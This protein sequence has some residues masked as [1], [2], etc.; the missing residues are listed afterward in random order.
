MAYEIDSASPPGIDRNSTP[1][2]LGALDLAKAPPVCP[3][4]KFACDSNCPSFPFE[5]QRRQQNLCDAILGAIDLARK[6]ASS[7]ATKPLSVA[8]VDKFRRIFGQGPLDRW[9]LPWAPRRTLPAGEIVA[10]RFR[11]A[12]TELRTRETLYRCTTSFCGASKPRPESPH[13][14]E[15]IVVDAVAWAALCK[16]EVGLCPGFWTLKPEWQQG[17]ILHEMLHLCFGLTCAW[18]QHD[19]KEQPRNSAYCYEAFAL[20]ISNKPLAPGNMAACDLRS[21]PTP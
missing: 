7:L 8:T 1:G 14:T 4:F 18:F 3:P 6:A 20:L 13:P 10:R 9:E 12:A 2:I 5:C 17:T 16:D 11:T 21:K 15:T 19:H